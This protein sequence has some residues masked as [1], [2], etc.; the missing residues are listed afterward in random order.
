MPRWQLWALGLMPS[1]FP[2]SR[3]VSVYLQNRGE[4][5]F[6]DV[7]RPALL[8]IIF[9]ALISLL[10]HRL[11]R[12]EPARM[13]L[14]SAGFWL[15]FLSFGRLSSV[16]GSYLSTGAASVLAFVLFFA[17]VGGVVA[18]ASWLKRGLQ[19]LQGALSTMAVFIVLTPLAQNFFP[20]GSSAQRPTD[21]AKPVPLA[22]TQTP[23]IY[24]IVLDSYGRADVLREL[25][26]Y[27]NAPFLEEL[28]RLGFTIPTQSR[29]NYIETTLAIPSLLN[30]NYVDQIQLPNRVQPSAPDWPREAVDQNRIAASLRTKGYQFVAISCGFLL[31]QA[32]TADVLYDPERSSNPMTSLW[33]KLFGGQF[34]PIE[35][36]LLLRTPLGFLDQSAHQQYEKHRRGLHFALESLSATTKLTQ[37]KFVFAHILLPHTPFVFTATGEP[38]TPKQPYSIDSGSDYKATESV[39]DYRKQYVEQLKFTNLRVLEEVKTLLEQNQRPAV[40][41]LIGDH[42]PRSSVNWD[43]IEQT[44]LHEAFGNFMAL[45]LLTPEDTQKVPKNLSPVN[46]LRYVLQTYFDAPLPPLPNRSF[47]TTV[48]VNETQFHEVTEKVEATLPH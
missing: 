33:G 45:R 3:L 41:V 38:I 10:C 20:S 31:T 13:A 34:T 27:D 1:A 37:P 44:D 19:P 48:R 24:C 12:R 26:H 21:T 36:L 42:G 18:I 15:V 9:A 35:S 4:I 8:T 23:D 25:Y 6:L 29:G 32:R 28:E 30:G 46:A 16:L 7:V 2:L 39:D 14:A 47:L 11:L 5:P 22:G 17:L 43:K 40:I